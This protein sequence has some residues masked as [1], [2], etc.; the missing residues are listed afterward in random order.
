MKNLHLLLCTLFLI[1]AFNATSQHH[2]A[3]VVGY[4]NNPESTVDYNT[5]DPGKLTHLNFTFAHIVDNKISLPESD[6]KHLSK[7]VG[8]KVKS[9]DLKILISVGGWTGDTKEFYLM[10]E[11][12][13]SRAT[14]INS[15][16]EFF[17]QTNI[18]GVD[19]DW[20]FPGY[21]WVATGGALSIKPN[22]PQDKGH[23]TELLTE[24]RA[25]FVKKAEETN[26]KK[27]YLLT[28][29]TSPL[30][31]I[32]SAIDLRSIAKQVDFV[33][34][35]AYDLYMSWLPLPIQFTGH[36]SNLFDTRRNPRTISADLAV[37]F[38][39]LAGVP[40][41][42]LVLGMPLGYYNYWSGVNPK[43]KGLY[44]FATNNTRL[45]VPEIKGMIADGTLKKYWDKQA[46]APY[47]WDAKSLMFVSGDDEK[48]IRLKCKY[49]KKNQLAGA[50]FWYYQK[51]ELKL[52]DALV[53]G[54]K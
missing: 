45:S 37:R 42:K 36:H 11:K 14:F 9:P 1:L 53:S 19:L 54:M 30:A 32:T 43:N 6:R 26:N 46:K 28:I 39:L 38:H 10:A 52:L 33:N 13:E 8:F 27:Q 50:M 7:F 34:I 35:M 44:Q 51:D 4:V 29:T 22:R 21:D 20:E 40:A 48:S 3:V 24:M 15:V 18:D 17:E 23:Y 25:A 2:R 16:I 12:P 49:I 31:E 5:F 41:S 47:Y